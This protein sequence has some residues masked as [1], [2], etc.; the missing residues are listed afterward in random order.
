LTGAHKSNK[1][2][3]NVRE[4]NKECTIG[5]AGSVAAASSR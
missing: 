3:P 5:C 1:I 4:G 2:P